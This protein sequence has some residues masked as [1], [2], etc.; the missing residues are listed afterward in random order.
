MPDPR[1]GLTLETDM[2]LLSTPEVLT[3]GE[4]PSAFRSL[5]YVKYNA[6]YDRWTVAVHISGD[7]MRH[8]CSSGIEVSNVS[9]RRVGDLLELVTTK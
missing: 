4:I 2:P 6:E 3:E 9:F 5:H 1:S 7:H 8:L